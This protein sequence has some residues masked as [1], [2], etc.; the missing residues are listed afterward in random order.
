MTL[1]ILE[2]STF[3][4]CN[5]IGDLD[6]RTS[7]LFAE[8]TRFLSRLELRVNGK[9]PLLLSSGK[10]EYYSAAFY[11]RNPVV[12][13]LPQ[14]A[15]SIARERFVGEGMQDHLVLLNVGGAALSLELELE[16][17]TDFA[18]IISVKEHDFSLGNP[19]TAPPL[20]ELAAVR[21]DAAAN[22]LVLEE[23]GAGAKTQVLLSRPGEIIGSRVRFP[24]EL[25]PREAWE[26]RVDVVPSLSGVESQPQVVE[27]RFGEEREHVRA[28]LQAWHLSV[29]R[30]RSPSDDLRH[31]FSQSVAD[32]A[33]LRM[34]GRRRDRAAA[35]SR[36]A[37]VHDGLR[38]RHADHQPA[39][40]GARPGARDR[41][42]RR[43]GGAAGTG[44]R[45]R[46][47]TPSRARSST[48][49]AGAARPRRGSAAYYGS[50]DATPLFL[51][52]LSEVWRWTADAELVD[53]LREP[54]LAALRWIDEYGDRDGDGFV[55]Y[56]RRT[57]RGPREPVVEGLGRLA[58]LP[59]RRASPSHRSRPS[60]CRA[61]STTRSCGSPSSRAP[62]GRTCRSRSASS[63]RPRSC[64]NVSTRPSGSTPAEAS[65]RSHSTGTS[66]R[67]T[68]CA[69]TSA[70]CSGAESSRRS[71]RRRRECSGRRRALVG[72]G[73]PDDVDLRRCLQ[74]AQL[75]RRHRLAARHVARGLGARPRGAERRHAPDRA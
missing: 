13:G 51:V 28:S 49:S 27:R 75:P 72:L 3:C 20:P 39:D 12:E 47:S 11:L 48:S 38:P 40:D 34:R 45:P 43:A 4:I 74:P 37:V 71:G 69:R 41:V 57:P 66:D 64:G 42:A 31:A 17:A 21:F 73:D 50:V 55:E 26:L 63:A 68:R 16:V 1:T 6:G 70:T 35:R 46:R 23:P 52:L 60:R 65:T 30:L 58:A 15:L 18:D 22:Q 62:S 19:L 33:A 67:S 9:R 59:R 24:L 25:A 7:G 10:V 53:R 36:H 2:G 61:T 14:D 32:L 54:A 44:G 5:E 8:D 56:E 29:P